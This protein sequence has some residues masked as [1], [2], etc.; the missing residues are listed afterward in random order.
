MGLF[1]KLFGK[2]ESDTDKLIDAIKEKSEIKI[3]SAEPAKPKKPRK[4]RKPKQ[5]KVDLSPKEKATA[6]G[7]PYVNIVKMEIDPKDINSGAFDLDWNDKFVLNLIKAGYKFSEKDTDQ[8]IVDRW[9]QNVCRNVV[10][11]MYEQAQA[12]P[13]NRDMRTIRSK[14]I[15]NGRTEV[16]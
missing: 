9:F 7:E 2:K 6:A 10:L 16:S 11:E 12:D 3:V 15:G 4:P 1:D 14:D 13:E 5:P 8:D